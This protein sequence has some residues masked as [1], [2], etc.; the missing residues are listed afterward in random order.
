MDQSHRIHTLCEIHIESNY[1]VSTH[2]ILL[3]LANNTMVFT[4]SKVGLARGF[5]LEKSNQIK[6]ALVIV[7]HGLSISS[8]LSLF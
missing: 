4:L 7:R 2:F 5:L 6:I 1:R 8:F 3:P